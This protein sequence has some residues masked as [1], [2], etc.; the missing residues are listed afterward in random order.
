MFDYHFSK[1]FINRSGE[2]KSGL[3]FGFGLFMVGLVILFFP[4]ILIAMISSIFLISGIVF[5]VSAWK[6]RKTLSNSPQ[7]IRI[8]WFD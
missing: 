2:W 8:R 3:W 7:T 1:L 6:M 4:E 5:I